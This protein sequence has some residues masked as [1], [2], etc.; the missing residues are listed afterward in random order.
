MEC[1]SEVLP[2]D[3]SIAL[4]LFYTQPASSD[5]VPAPRM[6]KQLWAPTTRSISALMI[7]SAD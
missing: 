3:P 1:W 2:K 6:R 7:G 4:L 5:L